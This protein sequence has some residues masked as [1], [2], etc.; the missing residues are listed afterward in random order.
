MMVDETKPGE[1][2]EPWRQE[3]IVPY[4]DDAGRVAVFLDFENLVL[5][6][7]Q[8]LPGH[9][10]PIPAKA[11]ALVVP[12]LRQRLDLADLRR[13]DEDDLRPVSGSTCDQRR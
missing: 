9:D 6:A 11:L 8:G 5:G 13:L 1:I 7:G 4:G 2:L 10:E 3:S 12:G